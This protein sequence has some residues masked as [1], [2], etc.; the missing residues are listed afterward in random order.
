MKLWTIQHK[1][2]WNN[3][4]EKGYLEGNQD[5]I[6]EGFLDS[7]KWMMKQMS[8]RLAN[9]QG[10]YPIWLW[11]KRPDLR[12]CGHLNKKERGVLLEAEL[13]IDEVLISDFMA[14]HIVLNNGFLAL[15]EVEDKLFE[16]GKLSM[17]K[18]E[19]WTRVFDYKELRKYEYWEGI[20]D[21]QAV[22]GRIEI[23][24]IKSIKE[25]TAR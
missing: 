25:F 8:K 4:K 22:T 23:S 11:L 15:T 9:Y 19:S 24:R 7:Y 14:W 5:Y 6:T 3:A 13:N 17:T 18:E 20:E 12:Q 1:G 16:A 2:A 10:N 21:L